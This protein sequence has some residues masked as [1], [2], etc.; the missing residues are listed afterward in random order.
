MAAD[1]G[2][3]EDG[4]EIAYAAAIDRVTAEVRNEFAGQLAGATFW[5]RIVVKFK[6]RREIRRRMDKIA[7]PWGLYSRNDSD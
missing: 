1:C 3:V 4:E 2:I 5:Q 7:P 6:I